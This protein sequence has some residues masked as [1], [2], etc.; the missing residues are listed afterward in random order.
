MTQHIARLEA[1]AARDNLEPDDHEL[2]TREL[3][4]ARRSEQCARGVVLVADG[5]V[6]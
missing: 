6:P 1:L 2:V 3:D 5:S 4:S